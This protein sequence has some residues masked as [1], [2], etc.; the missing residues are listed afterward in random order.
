M[1]FQLRF[2]GSEQSLRVPYSGTALT[3]RQRA[4]WKVRVWDKDGKPSAWSAPSEWTMGLLGPADWSAKW[5]AHSSAGGF[6]GA[7]WIWHPGENAASA[8]PAGTRHF[9]RTLDLPGGSK[10]VSA[11]VRITADDSFTLTI[12]GREIASGSS[13]MQP[14]HADIAKALKPGANQI[15]IRAT[16]AGGAPTAAGLLARFDI[17][18]ESGAAVT[19]TTDGQWESSTDSTT[20][21]KVETLGAVG[22][23]AWGNFDSAAFLH[24]WT[25]RNFELSGKVKRALVFVNTP[26]L[27]ELYLNGKKVG[28]DV[29]NPAYSDFT[30]R[31]FVVA[32]NVTSLVQPGTNCIAL[33]TA[34]GWHQARYGNSYGSPIVR[35]QLDIETS[36]GNQSIGTDSSWRTKESCITQVGG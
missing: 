5:I 13:W 26:G 14:V 29:L 18:F 19:L 24:P 2:S 31:M 28:D 32:Y 27:F 30:K 17:A 8:A 6:D 23:G 16:N 33:W 12:N 34:P 25:R 1:P 20:W 10:L 22:T 3:S 36:T 7:Q 21:S 15:S 35:A 9:R 11:K 4:F